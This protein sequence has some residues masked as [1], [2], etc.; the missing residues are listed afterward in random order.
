[1]ETTGSTTT[2]K[3]FTG[4]QG[5]ARKRPAARKH[6][7]HAN[8]IAQVSVR[9]INTTSAGMRTGTVR[10]AGGAAA[11][12][13]QEPGMKWFGMKWAGM[14]WAGMMLSGMVP[15]RYTPNSTGIQSQGGS[16]GADIL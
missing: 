4:I 12:G 9:L 13:T 1:M 3:Q 6:I 8:G 7:S 15:V 5:C 2:A 14:R 11:P 10:P 16:A